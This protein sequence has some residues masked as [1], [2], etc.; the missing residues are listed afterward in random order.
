MLNTGMVFRCHLFIFYIKKSILE[1]LHIIL[2]EKHHIKPLIKLDFKQKY[3]IILSCLTL[4]FFNFDI[5][6]LFAFKLKLNFVWHPI[7]N[8]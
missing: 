2:N 1:V 8:L 4:L 6:Y 7:A 5:Y 3:W